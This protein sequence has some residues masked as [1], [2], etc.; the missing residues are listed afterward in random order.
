MDCELNRRGLRFARP[1]PTFGGMDDLT[2]WTKKLR[3][4]QAELDAARKRTEVNEA[5]SKVMRAKEALKRLDAER[6][7]PKRR[8]SRA[9]GPAVSSS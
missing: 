4:A 5:A 1:R 8:T 9:S 3:E 2:Y 6:A 7:E